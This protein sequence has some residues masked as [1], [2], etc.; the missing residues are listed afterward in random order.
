V[1]YYNEVLL[2]KG[3]KIVL[4]WFKEVALDSEYENPEFHRFD[5]GGEEEES[6]NEEG[7]KEGDGGVKLSGELE[8]GKAGTIVDADNVEKGANRNVEPDPVEEFVGEGG[9]VKGSYRETDGGGVLVTFADGFRS[10][11]VAAG[12][13]ASV[14]EDQDSGDSE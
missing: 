12:E 2:P 13:A 11:G 10:N 5:V 3:Y 7:W 8:D 9:S 4:E 6:E 14:A 1:P